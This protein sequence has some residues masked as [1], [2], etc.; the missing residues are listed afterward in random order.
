MVLTSN[1][2]KQKNFN[3]FQKLQP[4]TNQTNN[5]K[6]YKKHEKLHHFQPKNS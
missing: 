2:V 1:F 6:M 5:S 4:K 3:I